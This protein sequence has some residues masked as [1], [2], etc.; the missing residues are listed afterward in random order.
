VL[1]LP[2]A[3]RVDAKAIQDLV[4]V[5]SFVDMKFMPDCYQ[6]SVALLRQKYD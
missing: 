5:E 3:L 1:E 6:T 2:A 4:M